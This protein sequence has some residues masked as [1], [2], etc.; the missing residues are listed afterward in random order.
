MSTRRRATCPSGAGPGRREPE[1]AP[2]SSLQAPGA[3]LIGRLRGDRPGRA[4]SEPRMATVRVAAGRAADRTLPS[5]MRRQSGRGPGS[6]QIG[7]VSA[8]D[9]CSKS[10]LRVPEELICEEGEAVTKRPGVEEP[11][12][13]LVAFLAEQPLA[14]P[15]HDRVDRQPQFVDKT[16]L[17]QC[18]NQLTAGM[19]TAPRTTRRSADRAAGPR[20]P[21]PRR[22]GAWPTP[23]G[24]YPQS[25]LTSRRG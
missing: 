22:A 2:Y 8:T 19:P 18:V 13:H 14:R 25:G 10:G 16:M 24:P 21:A 3:A 4:R 6:R 15:G 20:C 17:H 7:G 5:R 9:P 23:R 11:H 12:E 1:T